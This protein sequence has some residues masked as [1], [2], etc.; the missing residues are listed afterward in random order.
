MKLLNNYFAV[1]FAML[2]MLASCEFNDIGNMP[3][4][5][6]GV[7]KNLTLDTE[8]DAMIPATEP[9]S[10]NSSF[11]L[12]VISD[13]EV[14]SVQIDVVFFRVANG[15]ADTSIFV[16]QTSFPMSYDIELQTLADLFPDKSD[17]ILNDLQGGDFFSFITGG[18]HMADGRVIPNDTYDFLVQDTTSSG[19]DT[20]VALKPNVYNSGIANIHATTWLQEYTY[21]VGCP[22]DLAGKYNAV[23]NGTNTDGWPPAVDLEAEVEIVAGAG[24]SY[25]LR[26]CFAGVYEEWYCAPYGY[27]WANN[28]NFMDICGEFVATFT[29]SWGM[30][31]PVTGTIEDNGTI[32]YSYTNA[33]GDQIST[34]LTP[35]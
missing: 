17:I 6:Q 21:F 31:Y 3:D 20:L 8:S 7:T 12:D 34:V 32:T 4:I 22:T 9:G 13:A 33:W 19:A 14:A 30:S 24:I 23:S 11:S 26:N 1:L 2:L 29:D 10:F 5:I 15:T 27:C 18:I 28:A 35:M 16:T 25:Q